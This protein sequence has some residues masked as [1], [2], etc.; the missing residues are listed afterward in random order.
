MKIKSIGLFFVIL[1]LV[2]IAAGYSTFSFQSTDATIIEI[3]ITHSAPTGAPITRG[4][5]FQSNSENLPTEVSVKYA[6]AIRNRDY[7][8]SFYGLYLY[9]K[10]EK[11]P[12][13]VGDKITAYT[14]EIFPQISVLKQGFDWLIP[15][16]L[17]LLGLATLA[18]HDFIINLNKQIQN[19]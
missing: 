4:P 10:F 3:E 11:E 13:K 16:T 15:L 14:T 17:F 8:S 1:S 19:S 9:K 12:L 7:Q 5:I 6:Y 18:L 2:T